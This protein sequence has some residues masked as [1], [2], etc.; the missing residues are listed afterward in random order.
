MRR[1]LSFEQ[2]PDISVPFRFFLSAPLFALLA[3][4]LLAWVGPDGFISRWSPPVLAMTHLLTLGFLAMTMAGALMQILPVVAG[5]VVP[6]ATL[7]AK[8]V[9]LLLCMGVLLLAGAFLGY[10]PILFGAAAVA[11]LGGLG[12]LAGAAAVGLWRS[13]ERSVTVTS[14][15]FALAGLVTALILGASLAVAFMRPVGWPL[16]SLL[17]LHAAWGLLGWIAMLV[18]GVAFQVIP[19]FQV[20]PLYPPLF[21][22]VFGGVLFCLLVAWSIAHFALPGLEFAMAALLACVAAAAGGVTLYLLA[23]RKRP[24]ADVTT[25]YWRCS[26]LSLV[27]CTGVWFFPAFGQAGAHALL[28]GILFIV[29]FAVSAVN[30][31]LYKIVPFLVWYHLQ[32]RAHEKTLERADGKRPALPSVKQIL[33][34]QVAQRQFYL[35]LAALLVLLVSVFWPAPWLRTAAVLFGLSFGFLWLNLYRAVA[36]YRAIRWNAPLCAVGL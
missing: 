6:R 2:T 14:I 9:H 5:A 22:R 3:A 21:S 28:L 1:A 31:M 4:L 25:L 26:M 8:Y 24:T 35:H 7:V 16:L 23:K 13:G 17:D 30:G 12:L 27:T 10:T 36:Q 32:E 29:G 34:D 19:M 11:L 33:P 18:F 15:R 20:T